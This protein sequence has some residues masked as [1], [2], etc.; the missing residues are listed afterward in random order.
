MKLKHG[1]SNETRHLYLYHWECF[2]CGCN[3]WGRGGL[4]IHHIMGRVSSSVF[5]SSCLCG[6]CHSTMGHSTK[7]HRRI[8][9]ETL[10]FLKRIKYKPTDEDWYFL[11]SNYQELIGEEAEQVIKKL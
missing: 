6:A 10:Q 3:G 2:L 1:F 9:L 7:E 5:N 11:E 4:E 8:F